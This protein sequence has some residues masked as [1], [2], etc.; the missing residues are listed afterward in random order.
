MT[1]E[2]KSVK[3]SNWAVK[4]EM[5]RLKKMTPEKAE[6]LERRRRLNDLLK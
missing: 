5:D 4:A 6:M 3:A 2:L 1:S